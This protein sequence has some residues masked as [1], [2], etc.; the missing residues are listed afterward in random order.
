MPTGHRCAR[1]RHHDAADPGPGPGD[2]RRAPAARPRPEAHPEHRRPDPAPRAAHREDPA[3]PRIR[4][5]QP[6][7]RGRGQD[8]GPR[9]RPAGAR[10][11][12]DRPVR[13]RPDRLRLLHGLH[14][15]LAD[16]V[17]HQQ[18]GLQTRDPPTAHRPARLRG[19]RRGDQPRARLL[20]RL[21]RV[22]RPHRVLRVLLA[23]LPA[24]RYRGRLAALQRALRRRHLGCRRAGTG[25]HGHA[26]GAQ[27]IPSGARHRGL[28]LLRRPRHRVPLPAG[29]AGPG[30]HG[31]AR[32][33]APGPGRPARLVRP[34]HGL[35]HRPRGRTAHPGRPL[36]LPR[37]AARDVPLQPGHPHRTRQ[38][39]QL[40]RLRRT[41]TALRRRR[42]HRVR[43]RAHRRL[44][45]RHHRRGGRG[46]AGRTKTSGRTSDTTSTSWS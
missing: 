2:P 12:R 1:A 40:R 45:A 17:D 41:G 11:R 6:G 46:Q 9:S 25:W 8:P 37:P 20:S 44:R 26:A 39:R 42:G 34:E 28:D 30:H 27:R 22:Q 3:A 33:G 16:R 35:L 19:G 36:P 32:P 43:A 7:V 13:D 38:H 24:H 23:L 31:D 4:G 21:P 5:A 14:D 18:H 29:Q 15:A 10:Q